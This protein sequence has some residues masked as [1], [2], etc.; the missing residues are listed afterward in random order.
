MTT[1]IALL[2]TARTGISSLSI[3]ERHQPEGSDRTLTD[4]LDKGV[5]ILKWAHPGRIDAL[6]T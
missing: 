5:E 4:E 2:S 6:S 1:I 3:S